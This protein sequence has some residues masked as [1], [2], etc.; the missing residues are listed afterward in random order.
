MGDLFSQK[1][2]DCTK[3]QGT[4]VFW[5]ADSK[6]ETKNSKLNI[7]HTKWRT[8]FFNNQSIALKIEV[9]QI[10]GS[11][12]PKFNIVDTKW[13]NFFQ[14][15]MDCAENRGISDFWIADPP[16]ETKNLKFNMADT[17]WGTFFSKINGLY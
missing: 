5:I 3:N 9:F 1:S 7:V 12:I 14:K 13:Q 11:L 15:S 6:S 10:F 4:L 16:N 2:I 8:C 17:I